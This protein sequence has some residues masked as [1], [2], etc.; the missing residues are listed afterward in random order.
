[1]FLNIFNANMTDVSD[2]AVN[3]C[4][5]APVHS[6]LHSTGRMDLPHVDPFVVHHDFYFSI[7]FV[8]A[9]E[10]CGGEPNTE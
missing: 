3:G 1:M 2:V 9:A 8:V 7:V 5:E 10:N 4:K 6:H